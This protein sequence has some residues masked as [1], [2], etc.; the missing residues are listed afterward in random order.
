MK[1]E[2]IGVATLQIIKGQ[3]LNFAIPSE[4][5]TRLKK[6]DRGKTLTERRSQIS[7]EWLTSAEGLFFAGLSYLWREEY[8]NAL[9]HFE[10]AVEKDPNNADAF[11]YIG[12][13]N[14]EL[15]RYTEEIEAYKQAIRIKPDLAEAHY[16]LG[17]VYLQVGDKSSALK[18]YKILKEL[19]EDLANELFNLIYR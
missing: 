2:V 8:E 3:N 11:F 16:N 19:D 6:L 13:C 12:Y 9:S 15:G 14:G 1:G 4:R 18:E 10:K 5:I 7:G 17:L